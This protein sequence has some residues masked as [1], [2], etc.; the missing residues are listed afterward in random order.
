MKSEL[1]KEALS[2]LRSGRILILMASFLFLALLTPT[3]LKIVLPKVLGSRI[4][5]DAS[6]EIHEI[7]NMTQLGCIRSYVGH[8]F[9]IGSLIVAFTLCGLTAS[10]IHGNTWVLPVC[11]GKRFAQM[12]GAK[13]FIFG[14]LLMITSVLALLAN[15]GYS[16]LLFGFE[17]GVLPILRAGLLQG[18][19]MLFLL[20]CLITWG[21]FR[22][23]P[24]AA[25]FLTLATAYGV[26]LI[27]SLLRIHP[28]TPSGLLI[29]VH[30]LTP[31]FDSSLLLPLGVTILLIIAMALITIGLLKR[32]EWNGR[33]AW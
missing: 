18:M 4:A 17:L 1:H 19:Y 12:V 14:S 23:R 13:L 10:E 3:M 22:K 16:G 33:S 30:E 31:A 28:Y 27:T 15:Y 11:A 21:V 8:V 25:G 9:E 26:H 6:Q 29:H 24:I 20:S 2:A 7:M 32:L 5:G